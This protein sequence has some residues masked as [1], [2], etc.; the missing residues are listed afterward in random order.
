MLSVTKKG[1][2]NTKART[3]I[4]SL[5]FVVLTPQ[6]CLHSK[7]ET[8]DI[9]TAAEE[10]KKGDALYSQR[11]LWDSLTHYKRAL[12]IKPDAD[13]YFKIGMVYMNLSQTLQQEEFFLQAI[14]L[15]KEHAS[16]Y[17]ALGETYVERHKADQAKESLR[18]AQLLF[19]N[20]GD[21]KEATLC[22]RF[23]ESVNYI[24]VADE[25]QGN[26]DTVEEGL[27]YYEIAAEHTFFK[28]PEV[29]Y[30][31]GVAL[32]ACRR[33]EEAITKLEAAL[34]LRPE[35]KDARYILALIYKQEGQYEK[36]EAILREVILMDPQWPEAHRELAKCLKTRDPSEAEKELY[37]AGTLFIM[38]KKVSS[39]VTVYYGG[40]GREFKEEP[41]TPQKRREI[42]MMLQSYFES[43]KEGETI[44]Q[45]DIFH[46][47]PREDAEI[48]FCL[49][50]IKHLRG[51]SSALYNGL[52]RCIYQE[53]LGKIGE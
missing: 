49:D 36:A 19:T 31:L 37:K 6:S 35:C 25:L 23:R 50:E 27:H 5:I 7:E 32:S 20:N 40:K 44:F 12:I 45:Y 43:K 42:Y 38:C 2:T 46:R 33:Y 4:L 21:T 18:K 48:H 14:V 11:R 28:S 26:D 1:L 34:Y 47:G 3:I 9:R 17:K 30:K 51:K 41:F 53:T 10:V 39:T 15:N 24:I 16:A 52:K 29:L 22:K 8:N 13:L